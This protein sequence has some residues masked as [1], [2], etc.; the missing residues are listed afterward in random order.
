MKRLFMASTPFQPE[1]EG[2]RENM[3][4]I[5]ENLLISW[6]MKVPV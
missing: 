4:E 5:S 2:E 3:R 6:C 1:R